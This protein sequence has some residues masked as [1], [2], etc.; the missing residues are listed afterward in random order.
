MGYHF[1]QSFQSFETVVDMYP[2]TLPTRLQSLL[3]HL[4]RSL[5]LY[6]HYGSRPGG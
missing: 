3:I 6:H 2:T 5:G 1:Q 4:P